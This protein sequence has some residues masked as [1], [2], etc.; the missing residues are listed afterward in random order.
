MNNKRPII[1]MS[2][3]GLVNTNNVKQIK[4]NRQNLFETILRVTGFTPL[5]TDMDEIQR[6]VMP[7]YNDL[8]LENDSLKDAFDTHQDMIKQYSIE[9]ANL[10]AEVD[11]LQMEL[12]EESYKL[13]EV[14]K[15][16]E[17]KWISVK[18]MT[19]EHLKE[20]DS[21]LTLDTEGNMIPYK[22]FLGGLN[23]IGEH[24]DNNR[25]ITHWLPLP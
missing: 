17:P 15:E 6:A 13:K 24:S 12:T 2:K 7:E 5:E 25:K 16:A 21:V 8:C 1:A 14:K 22:F 10:K 9:N 3:T 23:M 11:R 4:N 19:L 20:G 18:D